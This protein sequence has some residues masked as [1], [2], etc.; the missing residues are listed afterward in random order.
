MQSIQLI[1]DQR[2]PGQVQVFSTGVDASVASLGGLSQAT[3]WLPLDLARQLHRELGVKLNIIPAVDR[4]T[5]DPRLTPEE[6]Y[7]EHSAVPMS[8]ELHRRDE[9]GAAVP[10]TIDV[11]LELHAGSAVVGLAV[12]EDTAQHRILTAAEARQLAAS[13]VDAADLAVADT[14]PGG[15]S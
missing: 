14:A 1:V 15:T 6:D 10:P 11:D 9:H 4:I 7:L 12:G 2:E 5:P 8:L 13:L 3:V